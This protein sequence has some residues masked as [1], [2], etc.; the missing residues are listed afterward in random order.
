LL[1]AFKTYQKFGHARKK[2][3]SAEQVA[4]QELEAP[5]ADTVE[6]ANL[7]VTDYD[8]PEDTVDKN[9]KSETEDSNGSCTTEDDN[10]TEYALRTQY[11]EADMRQYPVEK[12]A[13]LIFLWIGVIVLTLLRGGRGV[14]S[15]LGIT[16]ESHWYIVLFV[17][18]VGWLAAFATFYAT[19][20][21]G[22]Q[23]KRF[24]VRYPYQDDDTVWDFRSLRVFG[25]YTFFAGIIAGLIGI[26]GGMVRGIVGRIF[27]LFLGPQNL[28]FAFISLDSWSND[29]CHGCE[30]AGFDGDYGD[31]DCFDQFERC[32]YV[33]HLWSRTIFLCRIFLRRLLL[34]CPL[35]KEQD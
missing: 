14:P 25:L 3:Q 1:T 20:L 19:R 11:L 28:L 29:A 9:T 26:G 17:I 12:L 15:L 10:E 4:K 34:R 13:A 18:H 33:H 16:C 24:A 22:D 31:H 21:L 27:R 30:P 32:H 35:W 5:T 23:R 6:N 2:E 7:E 8:A